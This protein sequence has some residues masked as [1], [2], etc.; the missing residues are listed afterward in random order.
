MRRTTLLVCLLSC[1]L[2][3][4]KSVHAQRL[5]VLVAGD[6]HD[7]IVRDGVQRNMEW[8]RDAFRAGVP[9]D[10]L[11]VRFLQ[12]ESLSTQTLLGSIAKCPVKEDDTIVVWWIGRGEF[13]ENQRILIMPDDTKVAA[14][15]VRDQMVAKMAR[16]TVM[17]VDAY[18][19]TLPSGELPEKTMCPAIAASVSPIFQ[20][21]FFEPSGMVEID[22]AQPDQR[23]LMMTTT[24]GL[25]TCGMLLPPGVL[26]DVDDEAGFLTLRTPSGAREI[27]MERGVLW[28][29]LNDSVE[30]DTVLAQLRS[31]TTANYR[32]AMGRKHCGMGQTP[33]FSGTRLKYADH[34]VEWQGVS[35]EFRS[36]PRERRVRLE[37]DKEIT[38]QGEVEI[39][40]R[41]LNAGPFK[42]QQ[43]PLT[44]EHDLVNA[45]NKAAGQSGPHASPEQLE[46]IPGDHLVEVN[47]QS[48]R[49]EREFDALMKQLR[50]QAGEIRFTTV[51]NLSGRRIH[52]E[53]RIDPETDGDLG[54]KPWFWRDQLVVVHAIRP[55]SPATRARVT[56]IEQ[57]DLPDAVGLGVRGQLTT[58]DDPLRDHERLVGVKIDVVTATDRSDLKPGDIVF[59]IDG[60]NFADED[61]YRFALKS[62]R[63]LA[64]LWIIDGR[65]GAVAHRHVLLPHAVPEAPQQPPEGVQ[66]IS[67]TP[68]NIDSCPIW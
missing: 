16:L 32:Q 11:M 2:L 24:G 39:S 44:N 56:K 46:I 8:T 25:L 18:E 10:Q 33:T 48:I 63:Q 66:Y 51:D 38:F 45:T 1:T 23:P 7:E 3:F 64:G 43:K 42:S 9:A 35:N 22:S 37:G 17:I 6:T 67:I 30:W 29:D 36:R 40:Q 13:A 14:S 61:G 55:G 19:R 58:F 20:A 41:G 52:Y 60:Y 50:T 31:S 47:G 34:F 65:S 62:A 4:S 59:M 27:V 28:Q 5:F 12:G 68:S 57:P 54:I 21:L 49:N 26:G 15:V 53:T